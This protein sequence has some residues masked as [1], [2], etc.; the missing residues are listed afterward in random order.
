M[1]RKF[2]M[3]FQ[4]KQA[5]PGVNRNDTNHLEILEEPVTP[6]LEFL[7]V[8]LKLPREV[9]EIIFPQ[10]KCGNLINI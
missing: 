4:N 10:S 5:K 7:P 2:A 1:P 6:G 8:K 9:D 3:G